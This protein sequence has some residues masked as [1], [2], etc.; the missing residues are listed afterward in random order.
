[1]FVP[2]SDIKLWKHF[3]TEVRLN[4]IYEFSPCLKESIVLHHYRGELVNPVKANDR[5]LKRES[6]LVIDK[7]SGTYSSYSNFKG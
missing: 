2:S 5:R 7:T 4:N 1:M 3:E 6:Q